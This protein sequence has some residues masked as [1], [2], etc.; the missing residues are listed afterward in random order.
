LLQPY[1]GNALGV[2]HQENKMNRKQQSFFASTVIVLIMVSCQV[3]GNPVSNPA[4]SPT[5]PVLAHPSFTPSIP[6]ASAGNALQPPDQSPT[7]T[8]NAGNDLHS[9]FPSFSLT[10]PN[11]V[12]VQHYLQALSCLDATGW[13]VYKDGNI[14]NELIHCTDGRIYLVDD[15]FYQYQVEKDLL[16]GIGGSYSGITACGNGNEIWVSDSSE[17]RRFDGSTWT[18]YSVEDY[19]ESHD[20]EWPDYVSS[21]AVAPNGNVWVITNNTIATFDGIEWQV[22][23]PP[24]NY[25][26]KES[27]GRSQQL[28]IDSSGVV[29]ITAHSESGGQ[30]LKFDG[31]DWSAFPGPDD[32]YYGTAIITVDIQNRVWSTTAGTKI[33]TLNPD[34]NEWEIRFDLEQLGLGNKWESRFEREKLGLGIGDVG[35]INQMQFDGQGRLWVT[36]GYGLGIYDGERWT[37]YHDYTANL[38]MNDISALYILGD[39]P[40][41]PALEF[42][43]FGSVRGKLVSETQSPFT[44]ALVAICIKEYTGMRHCADQADN[45]N[46]DG[47]FVISNV[48]AGTYSLQFKL[49]NK[50]HDL[51]MPEP[52]GYGCI[53][54]CTGYFTV[55]EG[56]ET[57]LG[58]I[59]VES[60]A[61]PTS[62]PIP[63]Q[64]SF[65]TANPACIGSSG[66]WSTP[67]DGELSIIFTIEDC[68][69]TTVFIL[70][71]INGQSVTVTNEASEPIN[72]NTFDLL[73]SFSETDRYNLSGTFTSP[74]SAFIRLVIFK[75]FR[76]TTDQPSPLSGDMTLTTTATL[77][78]K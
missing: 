64:T 51:T 32:D 25:I 30:L 12:C 49:S 37:I 59:P 7:S 29:W 76:F 17:V 22:L 73:Q 40:Q 4:V 16:V 44:D 35:R 43:P 62:L 54:Y 1:F 15:Q 41:L 72:G 20:D 39:G 28:V 27:S 57:S 14:P 77:E 46:A 33:F 53:P 55:E 9:V 19:F 67:P 38:Y 18:S 56:K 65:P 50:W 13:H 10:D 75:G 60:N 2:L 71:L 26:F 68:K 34:T 63:T 69:I 52:E 8:A 48:P 6:T 58:E 31:T 61:N 66:T 70:G 5:R 23:T 78:K 11:T 24:G 21:L 3:S 47:S 36:T 74:T 45:V 42:K